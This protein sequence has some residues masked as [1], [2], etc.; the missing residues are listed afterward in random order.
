MRWFTRGCFDAKLKRVRNFASDEAVDS[1]LM[2][3]AAGI[4]V[5]D[6]LIA[7]FYFPILIISEYLTGMPFVSGFFAI[8]G[9]GDERFVHKNRKD[10]KALEDLSSAMV[11]SS[12]CGLGQAAPNAITDS[13]QYFRDAYENRIRG[14]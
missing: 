11:L 3:D 10:I 13:L 12:L 7:M 4:A 2:R 6:V 8:G 14:N 5:E 1:V 9:F